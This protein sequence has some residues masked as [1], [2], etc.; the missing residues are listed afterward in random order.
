M[1]MFM[2]FSAPFPSS[3]LL[4]SSTRIQKEL[5]N[6]RDLLSDKSLKDASCATLDKVIKPV[7]GVESVR[8]GWEAFTGLLVIRDP[9][10]VIPS[11]QTC[12]G[13]SFGLHL[14]KLTHVYWLYERGIPVRYVKS[15][16]EMWDTLSKISTI[17]VPGLG[18]QASIVLFVVLAFDCCLWFRFFK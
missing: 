13:L 15:S 16:L 5:W 12:K 18:T 1:D 14:Y 17:T 7:P 11:F 8:G 2:Q 9:L 6:P 3:L 10:Q 4:P